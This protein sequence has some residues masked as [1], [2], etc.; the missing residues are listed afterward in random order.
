MVINQELV[1]SGHFI[2]VVEM[3]TND[4]KNIIR[5]PRCGRVFGST[6]Y[7]RSLFFSLKRK[8]QTDP[9]RTYVST[10]ERNF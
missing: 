5:L 1:P 3:R 10:S 4:S 9:Y 2:R 6:L 7:T 8:E